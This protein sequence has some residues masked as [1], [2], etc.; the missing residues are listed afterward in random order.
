MNR[1]HSLPNQLYSLVAKNPGTLLFETSRPGESAFSRIFTNPQ[2][3]IEARSAADLDALFPEVED[4]MRRD[5]FAAGF[6]AYECG[7]YFEP[8]ATQRRTRPDDLL[9]WFGIYEHCYLFD[10]RTG[11]FLGDEPPGLAA[12][13]HGEPLPPPSVSFSLDQA[14]YSARIAQIH[15]WIR[16]GDVYQL[17]FTFPLHAEIVESPAQLYAR[18]QAAQPVDYGAFLHCQ[19]GCHILSLSPELFFHVRHDGAAR[20]IT[21]RPMKGTAPRGRT[22]AEDREIAAWLANDQKNRAENVM[23]VDLIRND[24]GRICKFGSVHVDKLFEVERFPTLWQMTSTI[25]GELRP[26]VQHKDIFRAL[27]PCGSVTGAPKIRAMQLLAQI[28]DQPRGIYTGAIGFLSREQTVFNVAIRTLTLQDRQATASGAAMGVG[29][30]IVIDSDPP[31]EFRECQLKAEFLTRTAEPFSLIETMLW[32][33]AYPLLDLHLDRL[34]DSANYFGFTFD[35]N[36][37]QSAL[38]AATNTFTGSHAQKVRLHLDANGT[39]HI[40]SEPFAEPNRTAIARVCLEKKRTDPNDLFLFHKTTR[41]AVYNR[42]FAAACAEGFAEVLF[43]NTNGQVTEGAI[44]NVIIEKSSRWY[45]PSIECGLLPGVYR[46]H[47][48]ETRSNMEERVLTLS[49]LKSAD[50]VYICNALRGLRKVQLSFTE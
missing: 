14:K 38:L 44:S 26:D 7:Q 46:R 1:W 37:I 45:T 41:R 11:T 19:S 49:E 43:L 50:A 12:P 33:G 18:L 36:A 40:D 32:D 42:A 28:E 47:L 15:D 39:M 10:H 2:R 20:H 8:T 9:A 24:L 34:T 35:R 17:N 48:L 30:G 3:V 4:A 21:T 5:L 16:A 27:F 29:S 23:I 6:F 31:A 22:T 25:S 13:G